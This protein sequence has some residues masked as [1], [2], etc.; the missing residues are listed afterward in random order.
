MSHEHHDEHH[1]EGPQIDI[2]KSK[3]AFSA[4]FWFVL[5]I[6]LVFIA[7][8]N[9]VNVM[10]QPEEGHGGHEAHSEVPSH[11]HSGPGEM[12][13]GHADATHEPTNTGDQTA[14]TAAESTSEHH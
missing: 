13:G 9:F 4:S 3:S 2:K 12:E 5:I 14:D 11:G 7:A 10:S 6:A 8:L 1:Q